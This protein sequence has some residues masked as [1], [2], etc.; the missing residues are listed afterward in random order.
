MRATV[1]DQALNQRWLE[2]WAG[3]DNERL[4]AVGALLAGVGRISVSHNGWRMPIW[5]YEDDLYMAE[6]LGSFKG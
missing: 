4:L 2:Y 5:G 1:R 6:A 3:I